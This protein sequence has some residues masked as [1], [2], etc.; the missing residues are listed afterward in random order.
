MHA[1][2]PPQ[3]SRSHGVRSPT[4]IPHILSTSSTMLGVCMTVLSLSK[5]DDDPLPYWFIDKL[6]AIAAVLFLTS[7]VCSFLSL[8]GFGDTLR[9]ALRL[10]RHAEWVFMAG[11]TMLAVAAVI[12]AFIVR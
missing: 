9:G 10:E 12:L 11:L 6:V 7:C 2:P 8:R 4:S 5:L 3:S 1:E